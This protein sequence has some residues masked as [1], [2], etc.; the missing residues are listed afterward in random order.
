M[1]TLV[2][3]LLKV[4]V[5]GSV[6]LL[7]ISRPKALNA[8]NDQASLPHV[9]KHVLAIL[10]WT[11]HCCV[12]QVMQELTDAAQRLDKDEGVR[13]LVITG[14]GTK[15]FAAG[16]SLCTSGERGLSHMLRSF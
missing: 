3:P 14:E 13:C 5:Q 15:A 2:V 1:C 9:I 16:R 8:L 7:T 11:F 10:P 4:D 12:I 6:G